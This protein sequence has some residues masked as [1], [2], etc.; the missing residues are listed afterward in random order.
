[1]QIVSVTIGILEGNVYASFVYSPQGAE[2][3]SVD[4]TISNKSVE[5][6][7]TYSIQVTRYITDRHTW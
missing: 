2:V 7:K 4:L 6:F 1:M 3:D 5:L